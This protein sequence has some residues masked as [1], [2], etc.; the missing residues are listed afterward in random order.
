M[1]RQAQSRSWRRSDVVTG[2]R[3]GEAVQARSRSSNT[4][5]VQVQCCGGGE[6]DG[7]SCR[8]QRPLDRSR[9]RNFGVGLAATGD[10]MSCAPAPT[11]LLWR[12]ATGAH[13][14]GE[15]VE[16]PRSG[17]GSRAQLAVGPTDGDHPN[18]CSLSIKK[19]SVNVPNYVLYIHV[20]IIKKCL[21][22][23]RRASL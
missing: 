16:R 20:D 7:A 1:G 9:V 22:R 8:S 18:T 13:Q 6:D 3:V 21:I 19:M 17:H 5:A 15:P 12:C 4:A 2:V 14:P 23:W 10:L 11:V